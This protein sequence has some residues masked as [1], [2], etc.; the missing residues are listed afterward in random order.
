MTS[1][2][3]RS[4]WLQSLRFTV[5]HP[6]VASSMLCR[7]PAENTAV[8]QQPLCPLLM[9]NPS[10]PIKDLHP[11]TRQ[12]PQGGLSAGR[13]PA[14]TREHTE[15]LSL[16]RIS[17]HRLCLQQ[18]AAHCCG[19][20]NEARASL[21][22]SRHSPVVMHLF[23]SPSHTLTRNKHMHHTTSVCTHADLVHAALKAWQVGTHQDVEQPWQPPVAL[24]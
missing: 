12:V 18:T 5:H 13:L 22:Q 24:A 14:L 19:Y 16:V 3:L 8:P 9:S 21:T 20:H 11:P 17:T 23:L 15:C 4:C 10:N 2:N 1:A 7:G 6:D